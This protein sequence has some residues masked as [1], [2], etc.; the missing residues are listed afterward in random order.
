M[1]ILAALAVVFGGLGLAAC[2]NTGDPQAA[3]REV[4][5]AISGYTLY[6]YDNSSGGQYAVCWLRNSTTFTTIIRCQSYAT[7]EIFVC[8]V[9]SAGE[10]QV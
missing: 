7:H 9:N 5:A 10:V 4:D 2:H 6:A 8:T 1:R 3:C